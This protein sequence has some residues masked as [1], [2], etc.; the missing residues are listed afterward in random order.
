MLGRLATIVYRRRRWVLVA[1]A[2]LTA[3]GAFSAKK[4]SSRWFESFSIPGYSAYR[5]I[6]RR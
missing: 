1:W 6:R 3:F 5:R 2:L 4:V